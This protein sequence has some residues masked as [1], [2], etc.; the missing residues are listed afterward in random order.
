[1]IKNYVILLAALVSGIQMY[2]ADVGFDDTFDEEENTM[3]ILPYY[4]EEEI[5]YAQESLCT[6]WRSRGRD[7]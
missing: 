5:D 6:K 1:M 2:G 3:S 4:G 7:S